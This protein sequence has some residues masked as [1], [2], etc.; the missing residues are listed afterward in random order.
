M[1]VLRFIGRYWYIPFLILGAILAWIV[2][3]D[4]NRTPIAATKRE[5]KAIDAGRRAK[6]MEARYGTE[7]AKAKVKSEYQAALAALDGKKAAKAKELENDPAKLARF[8]V[9]AGSDS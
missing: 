9:R 7:A 8:L 3:R 1:K 4:R 2:F 6:E 5:L